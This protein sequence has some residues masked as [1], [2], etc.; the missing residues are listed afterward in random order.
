[1]NLFF[2]QTN[3][4]PET[5]HLVPQSNGWEGKTNCYLYMQACMTS[6]PNK[7]FFNQI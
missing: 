2:S 5:E 3:Y 4:F 1:M 6:T 7:L